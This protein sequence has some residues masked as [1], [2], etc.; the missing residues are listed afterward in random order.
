MP[1]TVTE[2][3]GYRLAENFLL[4]FQQFPNSVQPIPTSGQGRKRFLFESLALARQHDLQLGLLETSIVQVSTPL[5]TLC[6]G[7]Q[8]TMKMTKNKCSAQGS[9]RQ[10]KKAA[11][12]N[13]RR[14]RGGKD[15][16]G[17]CRAN[18]RTNKRDHKSP[19]HQRAVRVIFRQHTG[20]EW[21]DDVEADIHKNLRGNKDRFREIVEKIVD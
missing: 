1:G 14:P 5:F 4:V 15:R 3:A 18:G 11:P 16:A 8:A 13:S 2:I 17:G 19:R 9:E 10:R 12:C 20:H 7:W 21:S 6:H